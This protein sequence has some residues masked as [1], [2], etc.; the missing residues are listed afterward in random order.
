MA[1]LGVCANKLMCAL[2]EREVASIHREME[3]VPLTP[4]DVLLGRGPVKHVYFPISGVVAKTVVMN[5]GHQVEAG[6]VG[7]EGVIPLCHFLGIGS[8]PFEATVQLAGEALRL[9][10]EAFDAQLRASPLL[11]VK[12][13]QFTAAFVAQVSLSGACKRLHSLRSQYCRLLLMLQDRANSPT[14]TL[15]QEAVGQMLGVRRMSVTEVAGQLYNEGII[16]YSRGQLSIIDRRALKRCACE[17]YARI[18][19]VYQN[20][21]RPASQPF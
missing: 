6:L 15:T 3:L 12:M 13:L 5:D 11:H 17:C 8:T 4:G 1:S 21:L 16:T 18:R 2:P 19:E 14:F 7:N 9:S 20:M 10:A